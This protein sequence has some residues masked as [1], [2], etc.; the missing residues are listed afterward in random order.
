MKGYEAAKKLGMKSGEFCEKYNL[1]SHMQSLPEE[2]EAELF[3][4]E[5][6]NLGRTSMYGNI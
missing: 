5:K 2:L 6:K 3:G 4:S 1:N